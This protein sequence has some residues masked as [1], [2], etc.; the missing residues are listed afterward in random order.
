M[1]SKKDLVEFEKE[2]NR[3]EYN[4]KR[5][6]EQIKIEKSKDTSDSVSGSNPNFP[7]EKRHIKVNGISELRINKLKKKRRN[8]IRRIDKLKDSLQYKLFKEDTVIAEIIEKRYI[9]QME[10]KQIASDLKYSSE[11]GARNYFN[12]YFEKI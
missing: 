4:L 12:R 6:N 1:I 3:L 2:L 9:K 10:W 8:A 5:I 7:Y 11:S